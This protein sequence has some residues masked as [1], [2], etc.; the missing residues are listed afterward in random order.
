M[1][2]A[3]RNAQVIKCDTSRMARTHQ[4]LLLLW[5]DIEVQRILV[6]DDATFASIFSFFHRRTFTTN[7]VVRGRVGSVSVV[8]LEAGSGCLL[9]LVALQ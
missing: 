3:S 5:N 2:A 9:L 4:I 8:T 6:S 7:F 1:H